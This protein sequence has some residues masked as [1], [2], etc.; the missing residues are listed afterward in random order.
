[1]R[2]RRSSLSS[3]G[4]ERLAELE[5]LFETEKMLIERKSKKN[6]NIPNMEF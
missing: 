2:R 4:L 5:R 1:M 3:G 6:A